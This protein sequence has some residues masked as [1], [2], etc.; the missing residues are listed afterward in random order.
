MHAGGRKSSICSI[1]FIG[2]SFPHVGNLKS[3]AECFSV[4]CFAEWGGRKRKQKEIIVQ[5][6]TVP[7]RPAWVCQCQSPLG[8][9]LLGLVASR[10]YSTGDSWGKKKHAS[11]RKVKLHAAT[12]NMDPEMEQQLA[13]L[14]ARCK[15]QVGSCMEGFSSL[16]QP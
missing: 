16:S 11:K 5:G 3:S 8:V 2:F 15:E 1:D 12:L 10:G 7:A 13:P 6:V 4:S 14:R 9:S